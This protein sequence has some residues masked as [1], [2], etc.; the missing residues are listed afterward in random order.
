MRYQPSLIRDHGTNAE[1]A[2]VTSP[3]GTCQVIDIAAINEHLIEPG[4]DAQLGGELSD[5]PLTCTQVAKSLARGRAFGRGD[6]R[7][8][9]TIDI[10]ERPVAEKHAA[11][12]AAQI[13]EGAPGDLGEALGGLAC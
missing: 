5:Q 12:I 9:A 1:I 8:I 10:Q 6:F 13:R 7:V 3:S 2:L 4:R 11:A